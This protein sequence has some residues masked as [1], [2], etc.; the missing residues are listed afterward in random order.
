MMKNLKIFAKVKGTEGI[1]GTLIENQRR[2]VEESILQ[3]NGKDEH[4]Q[5]T[6]AMTC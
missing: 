2:D 3:L 4:V 6:M 5:S 1:E